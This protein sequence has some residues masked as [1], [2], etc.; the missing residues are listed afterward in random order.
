MHCNTSRTRCCWATSLVPPAQ[1][2]EVLKKE[3]E[4]KDVAPEPEIVF[5]VKR[6][7]GQKE[8]KKLAREA[9]ANKG[10]EM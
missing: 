6:K 5:V 7:V 3:V 8:A 1:V 4:L 10:G 9:V 2:V